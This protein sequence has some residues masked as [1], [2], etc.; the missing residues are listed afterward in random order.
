MHPLKYFLAVHLGALGL[1][2]Y[3]LG[4]E[5]VRTLFSARLLLTAGSREERN[6]FYSSY[7]RIIF[8]YSLL[9]TSE[10]PEHE[11]HSPGLFGVSASECM[12]DPKP[13]SLNAAIP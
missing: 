1:R 13:K 5:R 3:D 8:P 9:T 6:M 4:C 12:V 2:V 11:E 7:I 10:F